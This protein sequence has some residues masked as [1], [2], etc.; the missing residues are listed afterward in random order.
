MGLD[1][2]PQT[3]GETQNF[4]KLKQFGLDKPTEPII[5]GRQVPRPHVSPESLDFIA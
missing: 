2:P 5:P 4:K 1:T 3:K